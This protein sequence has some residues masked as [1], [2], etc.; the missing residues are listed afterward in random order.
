MA[1]SSAHPRMI[2]VILLLCHPVCSDPHAGGEP[3][4]RHLQLDVQAQLLAHA[5]PTLVEVAVV[6]RQA[7]LAAVPMKL[8]VKTNC[9]N[10]NICLPLVL[11]GAVLLVTL[12]PALAVD[13]DGGAGVNL[14]VRR[15]EPER[16]LGA[17][18]ALDVIRPL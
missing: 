11:E 12:E 8:N 10:L 6:T 18:H 16:P 5:S 14:C 4:R 9:Q 17:L 1:G 7:V 13:A 15:D 2:E 3:G